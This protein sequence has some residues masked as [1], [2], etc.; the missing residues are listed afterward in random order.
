MSG[1]LKH[2]SVL[3]V[4]DRWFSGLVLWESELNVYTW[5]ELYL[6]DVE[7]LRLAADKLDDALVDSHL[8]SVPG[9][10]TFTA[11]GLSGGDSKSAGWHRSWSL[12]LDGAAL[13]DTSCVDSLCTAHDLVTSFVN[14]FWVLGA[15]RD[16]D[17]VFFRR[18]SN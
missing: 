1:K 4:V 2:W 10:G 15:D 8:V 5:L 9:L 18:I 3:H 14:R 7:D 17:V 16:S 11:G 12:D 6:G 13:V